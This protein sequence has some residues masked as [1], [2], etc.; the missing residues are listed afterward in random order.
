MGETELMAEPINVSTGLLIEALSAA[1]YEVEANRVAAIR[2]YV[3]ERLDDG[4]TPEVILGD[5]VDAAAAP[6]LL[7][8][9]PFPPLDLAAAIAD[10]PSTWKTGL[11][12]F[13]DRGRSFWRRR[14]DAARPRWCCKCCG[15]SFGIS[16]T[17][18]RCTWLAK[19]QGGN[20]PPGWCNRNRICQRTP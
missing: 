11:R 17:P 3:R 5:L 19:C 20:L 7:E 18:K 1:G 9:D 6:G 16:R 13:D 8:A 2:T 4:R 14:R 15:D 12:W 10:P